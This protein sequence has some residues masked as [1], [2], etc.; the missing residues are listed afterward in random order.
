LV[1]CFDRGDGVDTCSAAGG[2]ADPATESGLMFLF[3]IEHAGDSD[4]HAVVARVRLA[5]QNV[6]IQDLRD[7]ITLNL[8]CIVLGLTSLGFVLRSLR[9]T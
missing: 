5:S 1:V 3:F 7:L 2:A 9:V 6:G 4:T 8:I